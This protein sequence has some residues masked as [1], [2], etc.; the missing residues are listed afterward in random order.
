MF[1]TTDVGLVFLCPYPYKQ[2]GDLSSTASNTSSVDKQQE[3]HHHLP[4][5]KRIT[6]PTRKST[7]AELN[8]RLFDE[9]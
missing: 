1:D 3:M 2:I 7:I 8:T 6:D 4:P 9:H 5:K